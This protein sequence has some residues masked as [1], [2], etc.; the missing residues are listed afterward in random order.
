MCW[1]SFTKEY[2]NEVFTRSWMPLSS[3]KKVQVNRHKFDWR[4]KHPKYPVFEPLFLVRIMLF[5][6]RR[7]RVH[8]GSIYARHLYSKAF[9][10]L[11]LKCLETG[12]AGQDAGDRRWPRFGLD[13][14]G[15]S[16]GLRIKTHR[17]LN[18]HPIRKP[19]QD[20]FQNQIITIFCPRVLFVGFYV[21]RPCA[22]FIWDIFSAV[23]LLVL[24]REI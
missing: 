12:Y 5:S 19:V 2:G 4:K 3:R 7:L 22:C 6:E 1:C 20:V 24:Q 13:S 17:C 23:V 21:E 16:T 11:L 15:N 18:W 14:T 8:N 10:P 9:L